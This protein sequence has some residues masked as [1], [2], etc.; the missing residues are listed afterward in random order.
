M[1]KED[2]AAIV[3]TALFSLLVVAIAQHYEVVYKSNCV[4]TVE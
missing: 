3:V 1:S 4:E 2:C